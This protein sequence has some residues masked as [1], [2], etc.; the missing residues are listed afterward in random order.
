MHYNCIRRSCSNEKRMWCSVKVVKSHLIKTRRLSLQVNSI[1]WLH[2][3]RSAS[4]PLT[5]DHGGRR[6]QATVSTCSP[7]PSCTSSSTYVQD[8]HLGGL[9]GSP[10]RCWRLNSS[11]GWSW[12]SLWD[13]QGSAVALEQP[14]G[15]H[16]LQVWQQIGAIAASC[17]IH[18]RLHQPAG[19]VLLYR[20]LESPIHLEVFCNT[21]MREIFTANVLS[22]RQQ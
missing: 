18:L 6:C 8:V 4:F 3:D 22:W 13:L 7:A 19:H 15:S 5:L 11:A 10:W 17:R 2:L 1:L 9:T 20:M 14:A 21:W 12:I 16:T